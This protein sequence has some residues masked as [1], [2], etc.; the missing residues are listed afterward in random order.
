MPSLR[1]PIT[2]TTPLRQRAAR[3]ACASHGKTGGN[4]TC[5][6]GQR[7]ADDVL[8]EVRAWLI[9]L[10]DR[11]RALASEYGD[12][13]PIALLAAGDEGTVRGIADLVGEGLPEVTR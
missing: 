8:G 3:A 1:P 11:H 13:S 6:M 7:I 12:G 2:P 9:E 4:L 5:E 10:A